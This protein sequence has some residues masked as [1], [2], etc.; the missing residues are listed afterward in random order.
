MNWSKSWVHAFLVGI[1]IFASTMMFWRKWGD[2]GFGITISSMCGV[3][4]RKKSRGISPVSARLV[5]LGNLLNKI[6]AGHC[7]GA[8]AADLQR[9][10]SAQAYLNSIPADAPP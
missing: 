3:E 8:I 4:L 9:C 1:D 6:E 5:W 2:Q 10:V 7:E